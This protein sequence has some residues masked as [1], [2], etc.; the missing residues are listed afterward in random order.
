MA[1]IKYKLRKED[2]VQVISGK[3]KGKQGKIIRIDR[4]KGK[5]I[6]AGVN[7]VK[8]AQKKRKQTDR[9]GIIEI[10]API[11]MSNIMIVCRKCGPTRIGYKIQGDA[12]KRVC[13]KCGEA[14]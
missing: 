5:A 7:M 13:R 2:Q 10:E 14:L 11:A 3:D 8:K 1:E 12:K 9:G 6:V 4:D